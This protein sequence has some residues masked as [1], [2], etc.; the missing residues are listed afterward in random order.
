M[1]AMKQLFV[2]LLFVALVS[3]ALASTSSC[4]KSN[5]FRDMLAGQPNSVRLLGVPQI[6]SRRCGSE[7]K[8]HGTCCNQADTARVAQADKEE[9]EKSYQTY[10]AEF[11]DF[12]PK[13]TEFFANLKLLSKAESSQW[14]AT[15]TEEAGLENPVEL[16]KKFKKGPFLTM[17]INRVL[18]YNYEELL[19]NYKKSM[20]TCWDHQIE[21]RQA[22]LCSTCSSRGFQFF[23]K[24]KAI[25]STQACSSVIQHCDDPIIKSLTWFYLLSKFGGNLFYTIEPLLED[26]N[27][28]KEKTKAVLW[29][30]KKVNLRGYIHN[31]VQAGETALIR[32]RGKS[33]RIQKNLN[34]RLDFCKHFVR[35]AEPPFILTFGKVLAA[36]RTPWNLAL[37]PEYRSFV[38]QLSSQS[39]A[40]RLLNADS[41]LLLNGNS[42]QDNW[43]ASTSKKALNDPFK[44]DA[45]WGDKFSSPLQKDEEV[46]TVGRRHLEQPKI[47]RAHV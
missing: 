32:I 11:V 37:K 36:N 22:A 4:S 47:G 44:S 43:A 10:V 9:I 41:N 6:D 1:R 29:Y 3:Q 26:P 24:G 33:R 14:I 40:R 7:W 31:A 27:L 46:S 17:L 45:I 5:P 20:K 28:F 21:I 13:F 34:W 25:A 35:L 23:H 18:S 42:A 15:A 12:V 39:S 2:S 16:A 8:I 19:N 38:S 30:L